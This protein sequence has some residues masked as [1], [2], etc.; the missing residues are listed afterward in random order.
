MSKDERRASVQAL[1]DEAAL[2]IRRS[3]TRKEPVNAMKLPKLLSVRIAQ[4]DEYGGGV[5]YFVAGPTLQS[6]DLDDA[7]QSVGLYKLVSIRKIAKVIKVVSEKS[8]K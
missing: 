3:Q 8:V 4:P 6:V 2:V 1:I 5:P 7:V